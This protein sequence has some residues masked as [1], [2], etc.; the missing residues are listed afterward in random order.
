MAS[1]VTKNVKGKEYI[2]LV[3]SLRKGNKVIQKTIKYIGAK[4]PVL[5]EEF[6]CMNL[7]YKNQ[8][9]ILNNHNNQLSYQ[10]HQKM[11]ELSDKYNE[12]SKSLDKISREKE[13]ERFL[14][15]FISNSNAI[16]GSTLT[17]KETFNYLFNDIAPKDHSKKELFMASNLLNAWNYLEKNCKKFPTDKDLFELHRLVNLNVEDEVTLG[18]YKKVQNYIGDVHTSSYLFVKEKMK[19]L[20]FWIKKSY[21][22]VNDFE[23]A[24]Q[25][26]AQFE[27]IHP[28]VDG[29]G[30]VGRLLLNWLLIMK[31][32]MP[33]AIP[34]KE[35]SD[36]IVALENSRRGKIEAICK[37]CY[38]QYL[39]QYK[40]V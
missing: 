33:L 23:V 24:F 2:Y 5:K 30:R 17:V 31:S 34:V 39:K 12:Y 3:D 28:F 13:K 19:K 21:K 6:D 27:I 4:R 25:S 8:D 9:W 16:E 14:S 18:K 40:F 29:N 32:L 20:F 36:Y 35:R 15:I 26:H 11:K 22:Q 38:K 7:S 10:D 1:I 37:Y